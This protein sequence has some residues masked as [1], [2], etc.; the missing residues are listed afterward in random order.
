M[1][2]QDAKGFAMSDTATV[3]QDQASAGG[4]DAEVHD[5]QLGE[6]TDGGVHANNQIDLLLDTTTPVEACLGRRDLPVGQLLQLGPGSVVELD[7]QLGEPI[8]LLL[9]G[10][11]FALGRLVIV[12]ERLGVRITE[13]T[14]GGLGSK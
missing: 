11:R 5:A 4:T 13:V 1:P 12:G 10:Q 8:E 2:G 6:V 9:R 14:S 3:E 7:R